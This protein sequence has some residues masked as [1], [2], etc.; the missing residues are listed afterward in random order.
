MEASA[1]KTLHGSRYLSFVLSGEEYCIEIR[2][3]REIL[4]MPTVTAVPQT[5]AFI[6]GVMNLRGSIVPVVDLRLK[7]R[8]EF[9]PYEER[10]C[11]IVVE[12]PSDSGM[13]LMGIIV[14]TIN[15]VVAIPTD[16]INH[17]PYINARINE[18]Y[19]QGFSE[20][21]KGIRIVL[22]MDNV[23]STKE[24]TNLRTSA[25]TNGSKEATQ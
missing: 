24:L 5:P 14:D 16:K 2:R 1:R 17:L 20:T 18:E 15:E 19:I 13:T 8:M 11:V 23:L 21:D 6:R 10:T 25:Y 22:D 9:R 12:I 7:F 4:A 3:I